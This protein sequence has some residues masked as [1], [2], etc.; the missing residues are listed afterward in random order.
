MESN[1]ILSSRQADFRPGRSDLDQILFL[2]QFISDGFNNSRWVFGRFLLLTLL[3]LLTLP[4]I[5]IFSIN[6]F[7]LASFLALRAGLNLSFLMGGLPWFIKITD[8]DPFKSIE[9]FRKDPFLALFFPLVISN[10]S[11]S[12]LFSVSCSLYDLALWYSC[13]VVIAA[14]EAMEGAPVWL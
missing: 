6:L 11:A 4:G 14:V 5:P 2:S 7:R 8:V 13:P 9:L 10:L 1:S 3:G 12:L